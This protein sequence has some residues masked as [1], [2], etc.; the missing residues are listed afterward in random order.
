M[1]RECFKGE[2]I[3]QW[4]HIL[5]QK[6]KELGVPLQGE[7]GEDMPDETKDLPGLTTSINVDKKTYLRIKALLE[8]QEKREKG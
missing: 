6:S 3:H 8:E 7:P 4:A 1:L 2:S 5:S